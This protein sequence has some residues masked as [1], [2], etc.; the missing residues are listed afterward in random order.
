MGNS[1]DTQRRDRLEILSKPPASHWVEN[2]RGL[3][4]PLCCIRTFPR[5]TRKDHHMHLPK[6]R[7]PRCR[8]RSL[9]AL[10]LRCG[11]FDP[12]KHRPLLPKDV[13]A[14]VPEMKSLPSVDDT[15]AKIASRM[16]DQLKTYLH[17]VDAGYRRSSPAIEHKRQQIQARHTQER[18]A[19]TLR[20]AQREQSE[21]QSRAS[22]LPKGFSGIWSRITGKFSKIK[23]ENEMEALRAWQRDRSEKDRLIQRQLDE[24]GRLQQA[25][26]KMRDTRAQEVAQIRSEIAA[27]VAMKRGDVPS[28]SAIK[29]STPKDQTKSRERQSGLQRE[30]SRDRGPRF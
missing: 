26:K 30:R 28:L 5:E 16:T 19:E 8:E 17:D 11:F 7:S 15:K 6:L 3:G 9:T 25:I 22:R 18:K 23:A 10:V 12:N 2:L 20:I 24:R 14:R 1:K 21:L 29:R 13:R 27:Y 4:V